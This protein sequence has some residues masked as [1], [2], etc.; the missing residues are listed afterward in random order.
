M[1]VNNDIYA[2]HERTPDAPLVRRNSCG[3]ARAFVRF[4]AKV[5][6]G[7]GVCGGNQLKVTRKDIHPVHSDDSDL[8]VLKGLPQGL[9]DVGGKLWK[10]IQEEHA[11]MRE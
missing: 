1:H 2:I 5:T 10:L 7:A 11:T 8:M 3:R 4:V 9:K 6:A